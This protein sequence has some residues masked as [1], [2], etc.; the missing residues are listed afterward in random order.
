MLAKGFEMRMALLFSAAVVA[1]A[2]DATVLASDRHSS[3][4]QVSADPRGTVEVSNFSG[5]IEVTGWDKPLVSVHSNLSGDIDNVDIQSDHGR[6][7]IKVRRHAFSFGFGGEADLD[8]KI[9]KGSELDVTS[10]SAD[11]ISNGVVGVQRLKTVSGSIKAEI[12]PGDTEAKTVSGEVVLRG[13]GQPVALHTTSISGSIRLEHGAGDVEATTVSGDLTVQLDPGRT[14]RMRNTS[15]A[16]DIRGKL[17]KDAD[18]D[19]QTVSGEVRLRAPAESGYE[20]EASTFSGDI[21]DCF[22]VKPEK[23]SEYGPGERLNGTLGKGGGHVRIKTM[24]GS[25]NLC[26]K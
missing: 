9:P 16:I 3:D 23:T 14:I 13:N 22:N 20:Y 25:I 10:V 18:V 26:D 19:A 11:V 12:G 2:A 7:S 15:G 21:R 4:H 6:T 17:A 24:S 1:L 8:I 5:R